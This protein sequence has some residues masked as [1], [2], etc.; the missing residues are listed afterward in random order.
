MDNLYI[1][2]D[3]LNR[4]LKMRNITAADLSRKTGINKSS[5]SRYL[6]GES[7][8]RTKQI[9][10][11]ATALQVSREWLLGYDAP[12]EKSGAQIKNQIDITQLTSDNLNRLLAYYQAL[13][14]SQEGAK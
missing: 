4:A 6:T 2:K 14:D 11:I 7:I 9:G 10:K 13:V 8:P 1:I 12:L 5:I 3:R